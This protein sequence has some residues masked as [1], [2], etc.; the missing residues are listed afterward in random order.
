MIG[1]KLEDSVLHQKRPAIKLLE[2]MYNWNKEQKLLVV[3]KSGVNAKD[4]SKDQEAPNVD[5][6]RVRVLEVQGKGA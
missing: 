1:S 6:A 3:S 5:V 4:D 2:V